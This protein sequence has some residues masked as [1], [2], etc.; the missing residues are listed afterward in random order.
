M[1][2]R[3][4][5]LSGTS[6]AAGGSPEVAELR[7][8]CVAAVEWLGESATILADPQG[9]RVAQSLFAAGG[10][11]TG[12]SAP[13]STTGFAAAIAAAATSRVSS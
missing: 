4:E 8:A 5:P 11:E 2:A 10:F 9:R 6:R 13:S 7:A 1:R 12:A 3:P